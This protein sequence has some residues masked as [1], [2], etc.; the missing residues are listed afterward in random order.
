MHGRKEER[1]KHCGLEIKKLS[2]CWSER[3]DNIKMHVREIV[4]AI[5]IW[6]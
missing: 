4:L 6:V 5:V 1:I 2:N 3:E